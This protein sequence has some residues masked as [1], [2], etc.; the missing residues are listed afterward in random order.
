MFSASTAGFHEDKAFGALDIFIAQ[1]ATLAMLD[2]EVI[3]GAINKLEG[4][5][6]LRQLTLHSLIERED[7][8]K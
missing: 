8:I 6:N 2:G 1:C 5:E 3:S 7:I 4:R